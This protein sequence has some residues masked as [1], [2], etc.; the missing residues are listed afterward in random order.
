[1]FFNHILYLTMLYYA[2]TQGYSTKS[3]ADA[4]VPLM[5]GRTD[6]NKRVLFEAPTTLTPPFS[7]DSIQHKYRKIAG[8]VDAF[9]PIP[10]NSDL[11]TD[12]SVVGNI[13]MMG[14]QYLS[15]G[16]VKG[17]YAIVYIHDGTGQTLRGRVEGFTSLVQG[18][19]YIKAINS[20]INQ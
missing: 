12:T 6:G 2:Y 4:S 18:E 5:T 10:H 17:R 9:E 13:H 8:S 1:M 14:K 20:S 7:L 3:S 19:M 15:A 11:S 16:V